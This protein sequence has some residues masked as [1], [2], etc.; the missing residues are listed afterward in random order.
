MKKVNS[1]TASRFLAWY[2]SDSEMVESFGQRAVKMLQDEGF[3]NI[4]AR[5]LFEDCGYIPQHIC[6]DWDENWDNEQQ[7]Y[8]P[9]DI[10]FIND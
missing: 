2:F 5:Q 3:V 7:E 8:S 4:S 6:E 10:E 9:S 1:V